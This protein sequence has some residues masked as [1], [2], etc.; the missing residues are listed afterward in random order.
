MFIRRRTF[1]ELIR[2]Q[3]S[4]ASQI[5]MLEA[6]AARLRASCDWLAQHVSELKVERAQLFER[7]LNVSLPVISIAR[8]DADERPSR[9]PELTPEVLR[10]M[11]ARYAPMPTGERGTVFNPAVERPIPAAE[12]EAMAAMAIFEDVGD[13]KARELGLGTG[14]LFATS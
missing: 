9:P 3:A 10:S 1:E 4:Y 2:T 13:A 11:A 14:E 8:E 12:A 5:A 6:E 7:V